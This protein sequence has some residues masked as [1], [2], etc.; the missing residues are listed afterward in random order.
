MNG[1]VL[2]AGY[3]IINAMIARRQ[4]GEIAFSKRSINLKKANIRISISDQIN[5]QKREYLWING[6][7]YLLGT[8]MDFHPCSLSKSQAPFP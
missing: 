6:K 1:V 7:L 3:S 5:Q 8:G 2:D 4:N